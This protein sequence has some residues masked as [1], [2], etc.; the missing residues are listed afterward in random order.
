MTKVYLKK[1]NKVGKFA[2]PDIKVYFKISR[3]RSIVQE[4]TNQSKEQNKGQ[5]INTH[6]HMTT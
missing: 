5:R 6:A 2:L 4:E 1:E 3:T